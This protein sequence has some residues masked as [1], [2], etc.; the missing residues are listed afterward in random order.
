MSRFHTKK[1][2]GGKK[3][4][5]SQHARLGERPFM[6]C[7]A[8]GSSLESFALFFQCGIAV[9]MQLVQFNSLHADTQI[10]QAIT[11]QCGTQTS[12]HIRFAQSQLIMLLNYAITGIVFTSQDFCKPVSG[13]L[14]RA[15]NALL[16]T[17]NM[18]LLSNFRLSRAF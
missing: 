14:P 18:L 1:S 8:K 15:S 13:P 4:E 5:H 7:L 11:G 6:L 9:R 12:V 10:V 3:H 16:F 2:V 17:V